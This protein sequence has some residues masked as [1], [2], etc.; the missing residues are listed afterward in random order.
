MKK[1]LL[2]AAVVGL[3][4]ASCD[5]GAAEKKAAEDA[6]AQQEIKSL[7]SATAVME[8]VNSE[9]EASTE[10]VDQLLNDL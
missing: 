6:K 5:N 4:T 7:D 2:A 9:I 3:T 1:I 10:E 8:E